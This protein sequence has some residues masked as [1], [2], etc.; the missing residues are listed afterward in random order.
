MWLWLGED[1]G[2]TS[3]FDLLRIHEHFYDKKEKTDE[4]AC[5]ERFYAKAFTWLHNKSFIK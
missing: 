3:S 4:I 1:A 5:G 2:L